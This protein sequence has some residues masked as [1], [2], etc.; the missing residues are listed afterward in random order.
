[1]TDY[2]GFIGP[3]DFVTMN[4]AHSTHSI[5]APDP[6]IPHV[7]RG[8]NP[9]GTGPAE[10]RLYLGEMLVRNVPTDIQGA[11]GPV[12]SPESL[13]VWMHTLYRMRVRCARRA[14]LTAECH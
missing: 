3:A 7:L 6:R 11:L 13:L 2:S 10:H 4:H 14:M 1:V 9:D 8:W 12:Q 5:A